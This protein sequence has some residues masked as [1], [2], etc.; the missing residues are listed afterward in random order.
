MGH[1]DIRRVDQRE[2]DREARGRVRTVSP[3]LEVRSLNGTHQSSQALDSKDKLS[4]KE[5]AW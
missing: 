4:Q 1:H 3:D 2:Q 5:A